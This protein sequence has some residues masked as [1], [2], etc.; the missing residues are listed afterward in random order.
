MTPGSQDTLVLRDIHLPAAP[1][2]WPP[3]WGWWLLAGVVLLI[4]A[5]LGSRLWRQFLVQ[6][7]RRQLLG[8]LN[9]FEA[10]GSARP[11]PEFLA[12][13]SQLLRRIALMRYPRAEV[14][15]LS[16]VEWLRFLDRS[17]GGGR[18]EHG[19][20]RVLAEGPYRRV[21]IE[22]PEAEALVVLV[23]DWIEVNTGERQ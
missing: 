8:L 18:F 5:G 11:G 23:R 17:G 13:I 2:W 20:G 12:R 16:G 7:Q 15:P 19:P 1:E 21:Q 3:A 22:P 9:G 6:K 4:L 10:E 14:A